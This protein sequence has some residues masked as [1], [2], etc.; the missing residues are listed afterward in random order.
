MKTKKLTDYEK[1]VADYIEEGNPG[2]VT[3]LGKEK[4]RYQAIAADQIKKRR[5]INLNV[6]EADLERVKIKAI[7]QGLPYQTLIASI[8]HQYATDKLEPSK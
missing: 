7:A 5:K 4:G 2:S 8:I 3:N 1:G 6:L